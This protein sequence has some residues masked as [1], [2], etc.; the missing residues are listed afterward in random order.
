[1]TATG[2]LKPPRR[3][4]QVGRPRHD[5]HTDEAKARIDVRNQL[6]QL[7]ATAADIDHRAEA[8]LAG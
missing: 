7:T 1:V 2:R 8:A 4:W 3:P 6:Q 5:V